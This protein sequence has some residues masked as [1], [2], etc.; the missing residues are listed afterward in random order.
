M[1]RGKLIM[2]GL[3]KRKENQSS[4]IRSR[5]LMK[6]RI[7]TFETFRIKN[8]N[9]KGLNEKDGIKIKTGAGRRT[10]S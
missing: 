8:G 3:T 4:K 6:S 9:I 1:P 2:W 5:F 7:D 10:E